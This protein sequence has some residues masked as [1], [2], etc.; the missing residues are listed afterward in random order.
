[1]RSDKCESGFQNVNVVII[2]SIQFLC[3][4][5]LVFKTLPWLVHPHIL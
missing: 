3:L 5:I 1:M 4:S 2:P